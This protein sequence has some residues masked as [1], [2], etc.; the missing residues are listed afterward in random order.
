MSDTNIDLC[1]NH[2]GVFGQE[3]R[4]TCPVLKEVIHCRN[5]NV[6]TE[7][8]RSLLESDLPESYQDEW[9]RVLAVKKE[10]ELVGTVSMVIF[11]IQKEWL[12]M[13][14]LLLE[15]IIDAE[16]TRHLVHTIPHRKNPVLIGIVN[17]RG[18]IQ[19]CI[20]LKNL[21]ELESHPEETKSRHIHKRMIIINREG[22]HWV[23]P[24]DEIYGIHRIHPDSF[25][26]VPVSVSKAKNTFTKAIFSWKDKFVALLDDELLFYRLT[27][28]IQ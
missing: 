23:F 22:N 8:G 3:N 2:I 18:E 28:S 10:D 5:C 25:Q 13:S 11:R 16:H 6:Y 15:E 14:T 7:A 4:L 9:T 19:L 12:A 24:V 17:N 1:W 21:L 27:K 20:S 26:N